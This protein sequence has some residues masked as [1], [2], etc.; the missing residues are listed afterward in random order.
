MNWPCKPQ[1]LHKNLVI[2]LDAEGGLDVLQDRERK[3]GFTLPACKTRGLSWVISKAPSWAITVLLKV[4]GEKKEV[5][6]LHLLPSFL[7]L[8]GAF[9]QKHM[10]RCRRLTSQAVS[11]E[12]TRNIPGREKQRWEL[13]GVRGS[14]WMHSKVTEANCYYFMGYVFQV[15]N[16]YPPDEL[17]E[18][19]RL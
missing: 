7:G 13:L 8:G 19:N 4:S 14:K 10:C 11:P 15:W 9:Q 17:M 3:W 12:Y 5:R 2:E 16:N 6:S 18:P 1:S